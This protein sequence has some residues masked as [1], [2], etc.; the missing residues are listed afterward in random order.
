MRKK[1]Y[2]EV[3]KVFED[4]GLILLSG[5][6]VG[7]KVKMDCIDDYG[8]KYSLSF[9]NV[10]D[11]RTKNPNK[12]DVK[13][14]YTIY[15]IENFIKINNIT[16]KLISR[17]YVRNN[18]KLRFLCECGEEYD[19]YI[20]HFF[21]NCQ[22]KCKNCSRSYI[23][24]NNKNPLSRVKKI[25]ED[26]NL[27]MIIEE[28]NNNSSYLYLID[29]EGYKGITTLNVI[30]SNGKFVKFWVENP[31]FLDNVETYIKENNMQCEIVKEKSIVPKQLVF[32]CC[33]CE[34]EFVSDWDSFSANKRERCSI[35]SKKQSKIS[36]KTEE[37][38]IE[39][40]ISYEK[41]VRFDWCKSK[42]N[43]PFDYKINLNK[44]KFLL[45]EVDGGF[46]MDNPFGKEF[47]KSQ[48]ERDKI[49]DVS[50]E[51][52]GIKLLRIPHWFYR[53]DRYKQILSENI[54][55]EK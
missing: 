46:H 44:E 23:Y 40:N 36:L 12:Y 10:S 14:P 32:K 15:N 42:R 19:A 29:K 31:Y 4:R 54:I 50:C 41:E 16:C 9:G 17:E 6:Y 24:E 47:L 2:E 28:Y 27:E 53:N 13:N 34:E 8:Y 7:S 30:N 3:K 33:T 52:M 51:K 21:N 48:I 22:F 55:G 1:S 5:E 25:L 20:G 18:C 37:W 43:L 35:C 38:L 39:N 26:K 49:K 45:I 11:E